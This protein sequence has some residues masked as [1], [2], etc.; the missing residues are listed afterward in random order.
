MRMC[1]A[2]LL[3][4]MSSVVFASAQVQERKLLDR[5][6]KPDMELQNNM[7]TKQFAVAGSSLT[8]E[9][10][11]K[12]FYVKE[13]KSQKAFWNTRQVTQQE[14]KT[15]DAQFAR[16]EANLSTRGQLAK[17]NQPYS[18]PAYSG[19]RTA[20]DAQK[21]VATSDYAGTRKFEVQGKSQKFLNAPER[22]LTIDQVRELLNKNK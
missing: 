3:L 22:P 16:Q 5:L 8:K 11:T 19:V 13:A 9:A 15:R 1:N 14:F 6:L 17:V 7:Q 20:R 4:L 12:T 18:T 2:S 10:P 21:A